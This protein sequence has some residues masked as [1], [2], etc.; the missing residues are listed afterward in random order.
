[1]CSEVKHQLIRESEY[2]EFD[3]RASDE[4]FG[5]RNI[6]IST[7]LFSEPFL[8]SRSINEISVP[9]NDKPYFIGVNE[10]PKSLNLSFLPDFGWTDETMNAI[11]RWLKAKEYKPLIFSSMPDKV[12]YAMAVD[13]SELIHNGRG[14]GYITI[15]MRLDSPHSYS[16]EKV[17]GWYDFSSGQGVIE[18]ENHGD[19]EIQPEIHIWK[20]GNG[21][22]TI[23]KPYEEDE[24]LIITNLKDGD[25]I[26]IDPELRI[27]E[28]EPPNPLIYN[29]FNDNYLTLPY[30]KS[31]IE[32]TGAC[33]IRLVYRYKFS[34]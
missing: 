29:N 4:E 13:T 15:T 30:G 24:P 16:H 11:A 1:M 22:V 5:I 8:S 18:F 9:Y 31:Y 14:E 2:F 25:E 7:G 3:G 34:I 19:E 6:S 27:V 26:T 17:D 10:D 21:D 28:T 20:V 12:M 32:V 23:N 33:Q